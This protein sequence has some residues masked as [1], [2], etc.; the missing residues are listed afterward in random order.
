M[1]RGRGASPAAFLFL[2]L[3]PATGGRSYVAG[4]RLR[5]PALRCR[6]EPREDD[7]GVL[8]I[9]LEGVAIDHPF[10]SPLLVRRGA[11]QVRIVVLGVG[12]GR[13][14]IDQRLVH[15]MRLR[16]NIV[17]GTILVQLVEGVVAG[18]HVPRVKRRVR[19]RWPDPGADEHP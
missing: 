17:E 8:G 14:G 10:E 13:Y 5:W 3:A 6:V 11:E 2:S 18:V 16:Q 12:E 19:S 1:K 9:M 15:S 7:L 4:H